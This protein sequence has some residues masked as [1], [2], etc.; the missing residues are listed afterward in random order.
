MKRGIALVIGMLASGLSF[1][2]TAFSPFI[3]IIRESA[4]LNKTSNINLPQLMS[5]QPL[6]GT[7]VKVISQAEMAGLSQ[8]LS[9]IEVQEGSCKGL[10]GWILTSRLSISK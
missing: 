2:Q 8:H 10:V 6:V 3:A 4:P 7:E 5:C 9:Q 1:S